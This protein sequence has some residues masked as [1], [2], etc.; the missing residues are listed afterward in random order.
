MSEQYNEINKAPGSMF[1]DRKQILGFVMNYL[2]GRR[3]D[4]TY[5][6]TYPS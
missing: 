3:K 2:S 4:M 5:V 1:V 6:Q